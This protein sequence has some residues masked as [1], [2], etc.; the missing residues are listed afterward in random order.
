MLLLLLFLLLLL[1]LL[2]RPFRGV[3]RQQIIQFRLSFSFATNG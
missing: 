1:L 3:D 2:L